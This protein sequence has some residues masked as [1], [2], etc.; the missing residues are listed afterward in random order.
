MVIYLFYLGT[1]FGSTRAAGRSGGG[2]Q[3]YNSDEEMADGPT[4]CNP[5]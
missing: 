4:V 1:N 3:A 5:S 2:G